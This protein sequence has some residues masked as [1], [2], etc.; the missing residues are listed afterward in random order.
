MFYNSITVQALTNDVLPLIALLHCPSCFCAVRRNWGSTEKSLASCCP[1]APAP[2]WTEASFTKWSQSFSSPSSTA[3]I[4]TWASYLPLRTSVFLLFQAFKN[5]SYRLWRVCMLC[6]GVQCDGSSHQ[7]R[8]RRDPS[9]RSSDHSLCSDSGW[10]TCSGCLYSG[11][12]RMAPVSFA[13]CSF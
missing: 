5:A 13:F 1:S 2:T 11:G 6:F 12:C 3:S 10:P 8:R 4:W 7:H 9:Y